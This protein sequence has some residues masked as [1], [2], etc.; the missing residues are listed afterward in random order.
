M[1]A[2]VPPGGGPPPHIHR[3]EDETFYVVEG[4]RRLPARRR[5]RTAGV[6]DFVNVPRGTV[7]CFH[8]SEPD[9]E[10]A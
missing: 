1:E 6:G 8:N 10:R 3:N 7:H 4:E 2:V 5:A 9:A